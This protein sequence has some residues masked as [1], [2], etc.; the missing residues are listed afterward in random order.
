LKSFL[1]E[2]VVV[3]SAR[4]ARRVVVNFIVLE[5]GTSS[6]ISVG[7]GE[8]KSMW[9]R[10]VGGVYIWH[11]GCEGMFNLGS[12]YNHGAPKSSQ[13]LPAHSISK[14]LSA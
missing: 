7:K 12:L 5:F 1:A 6:I 14:V 10:K 11:G 8:R 2:T 3:R 4:V 9:R 13:Q